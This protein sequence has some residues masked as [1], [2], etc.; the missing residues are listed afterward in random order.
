MVWLKNRYASVPHFHFLTFTPFL[1]FLFFLFFFFY[2]PPSI[3]VLDGAIPRTRSNFGCL[4]R[5]PLAADQDLVVRLHLLHYLA[6]LPVPEPQ[7]P[8]RVAR[9]QVPAVWRKAWLTRIAGHHVSL[10]DLFVVL[11]ESILRAVDQD[12][13]VQGLAGQPFF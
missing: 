2:F 6:R 5:V 1:S 13:V 8:F 12:L 10:E 3:P 4:V 11:A 7:V 9:H